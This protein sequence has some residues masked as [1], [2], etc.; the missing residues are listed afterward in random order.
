M[1]VVAM[2][3][4]LVRPSWPVGGATAVFVAKVVT[5]LLKI[6]STKG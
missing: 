1:S 3:E 5:R 4:F 6:D 2:T